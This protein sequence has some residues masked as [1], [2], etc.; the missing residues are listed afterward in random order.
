MKFHSKILVISQKTLTAYEHDKARNNEKH[1]QVPFLITAFMNWKH[2][3][4]ETFLVITISKKMFS[5][6][7]NA[8]T[9]IFK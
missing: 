4:K 8:S 6:A 9:H 7:K 3:N 1:I 2:W 5:N